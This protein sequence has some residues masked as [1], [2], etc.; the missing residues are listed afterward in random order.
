MNRI[1][2]DVV[3]VGAGPAGITA[4]Y[5]LAKEGLKVALIERGEFPGAKNVMGGQFYSYPMRDI[6]PEFWEAAPLE[7]AVSEKQLWLLSRESKI[8]F[9]Y[10]NPQFGAPPYNA[11]T[12]LRAKFD[13]WY[14]E[15][16]RQAGVVIIPET[17]VTGI[18]KK[19][20]QVIGVKT[21]R[22]NG[23]IYADV[24]VA[25][26]GVNSLLSKYA[27]LH[28]EIESRN[29]ALAVKEII[30]LPQ[31]VIEDRFQLEKG[32]GVTIEFMGEFLKGMVGTGFIYTNKTT[33]SVGIGCL[34]SDW[35]DNGVSP[36]DLIEDLKSHPV[37]RPLLQKGTVK[38]YLAHLI[39]EGGYRSLPPLY[40][41]GMLVTGDAAMLVNGLHQEGS[42]LAIMSGKFAAETILEARKAGDYSARTL[43][44]YKKKLDESFVIKDLKK[45]S[46]AMPLLENNRHFFSTY[47][48]LLS[49][50]A[51]EFIRVDG[52][53]K[54]KKQR[55]I[56]KGIFKR[57]GIIGI[58]KDALSAWRI[59]K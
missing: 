55:M 9:S 14:A 24:V 11:F 33:L 21:G 54:K 7:R 19:G 26:D 15:K 8:G 3:V 47:P 57:R 5:L 51:D 35:V 52:V 43:G 41:D 49:D 40:T 56:L 25:A 13:R 12:V 6:I 36:Y 44:A 58:I 29:V 1:E 46:N 18:I 53:P 20:T 2:F 37:V 22:E 16:A 38:E 28:G 10:K 27:G 31:G 17:L 32:Q 59:V 48:R 50:A 23:E 45:Y 34:L 30:E 39:P 42:N 4:A